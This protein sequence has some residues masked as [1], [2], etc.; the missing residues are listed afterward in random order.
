MFITN[1]D[2]CEIKPLFNEETQKK[3]KALEIIKNYIK[4]DKDE[5][6]LC[7]IKLFG[8]ASIG[9]PQEEYELL[10]EVLL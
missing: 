7:W 10:K 8:C 6:G 5:Y 9:I 2:Q 4:V 1:L 3:L